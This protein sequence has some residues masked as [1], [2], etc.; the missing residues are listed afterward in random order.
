MTTVLQRELISMNPKEILKTI[1]LK[2][3]LLNELNN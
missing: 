1:I 3:K 2:S